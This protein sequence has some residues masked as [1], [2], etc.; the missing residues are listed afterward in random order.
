M[1]TRDLLHQGYAAAI[2][3]DRLRVSLPNRLKRDARNDVRTSLIKGLGVARQFARGMRAGSLRNSS[4]YARSLPVQTKQRVI[5]KAH[6]ARHGTAAAAKKTLSSHISYLERNGAGVDGEQPRHF[7]ATDDQLDAKAHARDWAGDRHHFRFIISPENAD[8]IA[9]M[10]AYVRETMARVARDLEEPALDW[11][12]VVHADTAQT[13][14]HVLVRGKRADGRDLV[15]PRAYISYGFRGRAQEVAQER[16]GDQS[17]DLAEKRLH[18]DAQSDRW[19]ALDRELR[20]LANADGVIPH[21]GELARADSYG[22]VMR[23][24]IA[25]LERLRLAERTLA[26]VRLAGDFDMKLRQMDLDRD[27]LKRLHTRMKAGA[28]AVGPIE[29]E[30]VAG[31]VVSAGHHDEIGRAPFAI[32]RDRHGREHYAALP[33]GTEP[34]ALQSAARLTRFARGRAR[35]IDLGRASSQ[36]DRDRLTPLDRELTYR[37][38][39]IEAGRMPERFDDKIEKMLERRADYLLANKHAV[40]DGQG[41]HFTPAGYATLRDRDLSGALK[42]QLGASK[43]LLAV[44]K[45]QMSGTYAG[46]ISTA[47]GI[48]AVVDRG[49]GLAVGRVAE[50]P[51]FALG[52][53]VE[54]TPAAHGLMKVG[55]DPTRALEG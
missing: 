43:P 5:V 33:K 19:T 16:L 27:V 17:R 28:L 49:A 6:V 41:L 39:E 42:D 40:K 18:R 2:T 21:G 47:S 3:D 35:L 14:A 45:V 15:I 12:A 22:A 7:N 44:A 50:A 51:G 54:L 48:Y 8:R 24:R 46:A 37:R 13:H 52:A 34:P 1:L 23:K 26:G 30:S 4:A 32:I 53:A 29:A 20:T 10:P 36:I 55:V 11:I 9:D 25:H 38:R 31:R